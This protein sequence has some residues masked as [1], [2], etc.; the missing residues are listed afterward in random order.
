MTDMY[1]Y[2]IRHG[3]TEANLNKIYQGN[4]DV[5]L[6]ETGRDQAKVVAWRLKEYPLEALYSSHLERALDTARAIGEYH[7]FTLNIR[8]DLQEISLG[9]WQGK[10]REEV[11]REY[12]DFIRARKEKNDFY[13][14][15]V[16]GGESYEDLEKRAMGALN[17]IVKDSEHD[18]VAL[19]T[20]G[21]VIK[22]II[23]HILGIPHDKR[24]LVDVYNTSITLLRYSPEKDRYKIVS[25]NDTAHL[26]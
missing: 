26:Q 6:N 9:E 25:M 24:R 11:K 13:T 18:Q 17:S 7:D 5:P 2:L 16:P 23:G 22:S 10:S 3:Q 14:T 12:P 21:G 1:I 4:A 19:I 8:Q 15:A 20:H